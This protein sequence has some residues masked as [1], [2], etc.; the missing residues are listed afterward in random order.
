MFSLAKRAFLSLFLVISLFS[1]Q[2]IC[3]SMFGGVPIISDQEYQAMTPQQ[4]KEYEQQLQQQI[5]TMPPEQ[6]EAFMN[7]FAQAVFE[8]LSPEE[9]QQVVDE[10]ARVEA[11]NEEEQKAYVAKMEKE[12]EQ[13]IAAEEAARK[14][15]EAAEKAPRPA[16]SEVQPEPA[17]EK[18][19]KPVKVG[20]KEK[21]VKEAIVLINEII[22]GI[23]SFVTKMKSRPDLS[24]KLAKWGRKKQI[25][26]WDGGFVWKKFKDKLDAFRAELD[27]VKDRDVKTKTHK[28]LYDLIENE[29]LYTRIYNLSVDLTNYEP[30]VRGQKG[31]PLA[32][33]IKQKSN[34]ATRSLIDAFTA[35]LFAPKDDI[36]TAIGNVIK[37]YDP[38]AAKLRQEEEARAKKALAEAKKTRRVSKVKVVGEAPRADF[39]DYDD[40]FRDMDDYGY[41]GPSGRDYDYNSPRARSRR[42]ADRKPSTTPSAKGAPKKETPKKKAPE[43]KKEEKKDEELRKDRI[44]NRQLKG[45]N[46]TLDGILT[47]VEENG[48]I[49]ILEKYLKG[50]KFD[51][52]LAKAVKDISDDLS[53]AANKL[54]VLGQ[55]LKKLK[56][57]ERNSF[58]KAIK[59]IGK[60]Y[61]DNLKEITSTIERIQKQPSFVKGLSR[62]MQWKH[63]GE[64][65]ADILEAQ[66]TIE[67][68]V[69]VGKGVPTQAQQQAIDTAKKAF[70]TLPSQK[71]LEEV[72]VPTPLP[73]LAKAIKDFVAKA[74][75]LA[76]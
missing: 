30:T 3:A 75:E 57:E 53:I 21:A 18:S 62:E 59:K 54:D 20:E 49:L 2:Q 6:Q 34:K 39:Y 19:V 44:A 69:A 23:D 46:D 67:K 65:P 14:K 61:N 17:K 7:D 52:R 27:T 40:S 66:K 70:Q 64:F 33:N 58:K 68:A 42:T 26:S 43:K 73:K 5:A 74:K 63:F 41:S 29:V 12:L 71:F 1:A 47:T 25:N 31:K 55:R 45:L 51:K 8:N 35:Q 13:M 4:R 32:K 9:Q 10:V 38:K 72:R 48:N 16:A 36:V 22:E 28:Y 15:Q 37:K 76:K 56:L 50:N 60:E 24:Y 11:M